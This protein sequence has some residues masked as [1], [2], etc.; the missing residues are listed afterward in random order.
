[1][2]TKFQ[3]AAI[4]QIDALGGIVKSSAWTTGSGRHAK[5]RAIPPGFAKF[6]RE[7]FDTHTLQVKAYFVANRRVSVVIARSPLQEWVHATLDNAL[8]ASNKGASK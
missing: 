5:G 6:Y 2:T 7:R 4:D 8:D 1:M 3:Q